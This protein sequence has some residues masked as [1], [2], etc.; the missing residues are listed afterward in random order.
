MEFCRESLKPRAGRFRRVCLIGKPFQALAPVAVGAVI[1]ALYEQ[2]DIPGNHRLNFGWI[3]PDVFGRIYER[4]LSTILSEG[5]PPAQTSLFEPDARGVKEITQ[6]R[7]G[8]VYYTP[9]PLVRILTQRAIDIACPEGLRTDNL[10]RIA[11]FACG[12]GAFL[13]GALDKV[14]KSFPV[15][16]R[17]DI[18]KRI[19]NDRLLIGVDVDPRA[20]ALAR[21]N[22][23]LR[24]AQEKAMLPLPGVDQCVLAGDSLAKELPNDLDDLEYGVIV[25]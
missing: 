20:V 9:Q 18:A 14:L 19:I 6:Q 21:L 12:S 25:W 22:L 16:Q 24:L 5:P 10:P 11:D 13:A 2:E 4:Y 3:D 15:D 1:T 7:Q 8:G 23:Y 17:S